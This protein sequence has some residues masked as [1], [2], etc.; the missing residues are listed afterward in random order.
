MQRDDDMVGIDVTSMFTQDATSNLFQLQLNDRDTRMFTNPPAQPAN[1]PVNCG[2][3][4]AQLLGLITPAVSEEMTARREGVF[5]AN[6]VNTLNGIIGHKE[7]TAVRE[8]ITLNALTNIRNKLFPGFATFVLATR[9][10]PITN[11]ETT[12]HYF[13]M[14]RADGILYLVDPQ[15]RRTFA[16]PDEIAQYLIAEGLTGT[17]YSLELKTPLTK[18]E[19]RSF[20]IEHFLADN[21]SRC[22][23]GGKRKNRRRT[24]K[25]KKQHELRTR[26]YRTKRR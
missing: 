21:L 6:W 17:L 18:T 5:L 15:I 11:I 13:V 23:T 7:L 12:G 19:Q 9:V 26:K 10:D 16:G 22:R 1:D 25:R 2:A 14:A 3:V 20:Y 24:V 8:A 4:T